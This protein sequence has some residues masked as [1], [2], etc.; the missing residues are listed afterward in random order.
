MVLAFLKAEIDSLDHRGNIEGALRA[1]GYSRAIVDNADLGNS[2]ENLARAQAL[3][4]SR[5]GLFVGFPDNVIWQRISLSIEEL[6][7]VKY[8]CQDVFV[9]ASGGTRLVSDGA[10]NFE[11]GAFDEETSS[12]ILGIEVAVK[13]G[14]RLPELIVVGESEDSGLI[15]LEGHKRA[16][17]YVRTAG[18]FPK[19]VEAIAGFSRDL[20]DWK[21]H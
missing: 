5:A 13:R 15:L 21:W 16:T 17:A 19:G 4:Y 10:R 7:R 8:I 6:G 18:C 3:S 9:K 14:R 1:R 20:N 11:A 12:R 2:G